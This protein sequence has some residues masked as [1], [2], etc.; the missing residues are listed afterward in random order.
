MK[1]HENCENDIEEVQKL[2]R[3]TDI[4]THKDIEKT[5]KHARILISVQKTCIINAN[6]LFNLSIVDEHESQSASFNSAT[7]HLIS[8]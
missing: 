8:P 2:W 5:L 3:P 1:I 4:L 7:S 6:Y